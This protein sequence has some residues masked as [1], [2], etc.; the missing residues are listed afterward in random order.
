MSSIKNFTKMYEEMCS[1]IK[2]AIKEEVV[3]EEYNETMGGE[4]DDGIIIIK[5]AWNQWLKGPATE[6]SDIKPAKKELM[7]YIE[8]LVFK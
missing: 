2:P 6:K 1:G 5:K 3:T 7:Q 8:K 4:L